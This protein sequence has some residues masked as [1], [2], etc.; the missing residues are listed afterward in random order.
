MK[1][2]LATF[3]VLLGI[4]CTPPAPVTAPTP[5]TIAAGFNQAWNGVIDVLAEE[6]VPVKTLDR[7]SGFVVAEVGTMDLATLE[8]FTSC[9]GFMDLMVNSERYGVASYN[10]LVRGDSTT[11]NVKVTARFTHGSGLCSTKNVFES[12]FQASVKARAEAAAHASH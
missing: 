1:H 2:T 3:A 9:G 12:A 7:S 5:T 11:S 6:N 4:A 10:I 8:K